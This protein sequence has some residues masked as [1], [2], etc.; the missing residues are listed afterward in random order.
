MLQYQSLLFQTIS[1]NISNE[2][3]IVSRFVIAVL[4]P[5]RSFCITLRNTYTP[6]LVITVTLLFNYLWFTCN[7]LLLCGDVEL[8][9]GPNQNSAKEI[10][11]Y[12]WNLNSIPA[13]NFAKLVLL[14]AYNSIHMCDIICLS[15]TCL[16]STFLHDDSNSEIP[17]YNLVIRQIKTWR[18]L[19]VFTIT[20]IWL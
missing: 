15:K 3:S 4:S 2:F 5:R 19:L 20:V 11:V 13:Y 7:L 6:I 17:G 8:N 10:S 12:H 14:K 18:C 9:S 16:D 1:S